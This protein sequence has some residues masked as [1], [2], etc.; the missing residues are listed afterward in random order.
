MEA[1]I[2]IKILSMPLDQEKDA[3]VNFN[4]GYSDRNEF[5][6]S[7]K[8]ILNSKALFFKIEDKID[9]FCFTLFSTATSASSVLKIIRSCQVEYM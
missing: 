3:I 5:C 8:S 6:F 7:K 9:N 4:I 1:A 2:L